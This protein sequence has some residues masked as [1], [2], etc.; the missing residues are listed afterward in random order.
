MLLLQRGSFVSQ[1]AVG[2]ID[3]RD[4]AMAKRIN[5]TLSFADETDSDD[6]DWTAP[7]VQYV[8]SP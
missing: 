1:E 7:D 5:A 3:S 2:E 6:D 4:R 8:V